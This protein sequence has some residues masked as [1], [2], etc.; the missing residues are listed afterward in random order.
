MS[1]LVPLG[2]LGL[3]GIIALIIIYIIKPNYQNKFIS[4]TFIWKLSLKYKRKRIPLNKLRNILLFICQVAI[5]T[6]AAFILAQPIINQDD[7]D[8]AGESIIIIDASASMHT[9]TNF[10]TRLERA[11]E[12]ALEDAKTALENG[13]KVSVILASAES[14]FLVQQAS[15]DQADMVYQAFDG[16]ITTPEEYYTFGTPDIDGAMAKAEQITSYAKNSS[17]FAIKPGCLGEVPPRITASQL[18]L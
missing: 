6:G 15:K 13:K 9:E 16:L 8:S 14:S 7:S 17:A 12:K 2:L 1:L 3:I 18:L 4:S 11:A 10:K 5:I